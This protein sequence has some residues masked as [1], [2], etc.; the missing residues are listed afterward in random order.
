MM[1]IEKQI[2]NMLTQYDNTRYI[3]TTDKNKLNIINNFIDD[4]LNLGIFEGNK[5]NFYLEIQIKK[6]KK[7]PT[8]I[9]AGEYEGIYFEQYK[10]L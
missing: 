2:E 10:K 8:K 6:I 7:Q 5:G 1:K 9:I 3:E 4:N